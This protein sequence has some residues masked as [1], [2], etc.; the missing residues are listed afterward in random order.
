MTIQIHTKSTPNAAGNRIELDG[1]ECWS[2]GD[3][4]AQ[5]YYNVVKAKGLGHVLISY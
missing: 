4:L 2:D 3:A 5:C 1:S